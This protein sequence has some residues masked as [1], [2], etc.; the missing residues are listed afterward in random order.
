M[1]Y[2]ANHKE[3]VRE[4]EKHGI[5]I[6]EVI[7]GWLLL[8][9]SGLTVEQKQLI[10]GRVKDLKETDVEEALYYLLG[11]DY[12]GRNSADDGR[13]AKWTTSRYGRWFETC[14]SSYRG[15]TRELPPRT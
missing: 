12:R 3:A 5:K 4:V 7:S 15:V 2:V 11:Q 10:Q 9:R 14:V 13:P 8:K 1:Q 6:P